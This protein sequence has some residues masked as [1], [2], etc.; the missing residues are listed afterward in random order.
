MIS[1][2]AERPS[3]LPM[4]KP[5]NTHATARPRSFS[6]TDLA[7][8]SVAAAGEMPSPRPTSTRE[9]NSAL[10]SPATKGTAIVAADQMKTPMGNILAPPNLVA[11]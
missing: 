7:M 2:D 6:G 4:L 1:G 11:R 9:M 3:T 8:T 10:V 5:L